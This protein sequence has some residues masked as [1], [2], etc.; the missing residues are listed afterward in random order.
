VLTIV[1]GEHDVCVLPQQ[2]AA[3]NVVKD[4]QPAQ[5]NS[6]PTVAQCCSTTAAFT[7]LDCCD[8]GTR[9]LAVLY[10]FQIT[11]HLLASTPAAGSN[12]L[13]IM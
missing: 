1:A 3:V 6:M 5:Q 11:K 4:L 7:T 12:Q 13:D 10:S 8:A 9:Q 2:R